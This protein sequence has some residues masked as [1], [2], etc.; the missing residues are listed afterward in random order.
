MIYKCFLICIVL[1]CVLVVGVGFGFVFVDMVYVVV[2]MVKIFVLGFY[3]V[4]LGDFEIIVLF[5]GMVDLLVDQLLMKIILQVVNKVFVVLFEKVLLEILVNVFL[6]N[7][8]S[9]L[10]L[11]DIGV[12]MLFGFILGKLF[13]SLKVLGYQLEQVD[14]VIFMYMYL[15]YVGGLIKDGKIVFFYV[16][17]CVDK[18]DV[19]YWLV[20]VNLDKVVEVDKGMF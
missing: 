5:D 20:K 4:M 13:D 7:I 15:D 19:D 6:V 16:V 11:I 14:E 10:V 18:C 9:K 12:G 3:C 8:G 17:V 1:F 2:L